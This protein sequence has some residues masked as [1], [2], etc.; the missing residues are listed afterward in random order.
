MATLTNNGVALKKKNNL[1][2]GMVIHGV[3]PYYI[4]RSG[5]KALIVM[6]MYLIAVKVLL[7]CLHVH[8]AYILDVHVTCTLHY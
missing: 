3:P 7:M 1:T 8:V 4:K 5:T 6:Y 2:K